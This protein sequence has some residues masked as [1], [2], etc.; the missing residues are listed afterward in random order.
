MHTRTVWSFVAGGCLGLWGLA[1]GGSLAQETPPNPPPVAEVTSTAEVEAL[2]IRLQEALKAIDDLEWELQ[3]A[4][5]DV[6][7]L[8]RERLRILEEFQTSAEP[9]LLGAF[10]ARDV[11]DRAVDLLQATR[12][13][14]QAERDRILQLV[15]FEPTPGAGADTASR[16]PWESLKGIGKRWGAR[17]R[18]IARQIAVLGGSYETPSFAPFRVPG[19]HKS[20]HDRITEGGLEG[21]GLEGVKSKIARMVRAVDWDETSVTGGRLRPN[22]LYRSAHHCDRGRVLTH[23]QAFRNG[24]ARVREQEDVFLQAFKSN[25]DEK[26][27]RALGAL[28]HALQDFFSHSN[29][30]DLEPSEQGSALRLLGGDPLTSYPPGLKITAY[31]PESGEP[32]EPGDDALDFVHDLN[33]K[34]DERMNAETR[35]PAVHAPSITKFQAHFEAAVIATRAEV[36]HLH[37]RLSREDPD[38]NVKPK[39]KNFGRGRKLR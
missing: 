20:V 33:C 13:W 16:D 7:D 15:D 36:L 11:A 22:A 31:F 2:R 34:D 26:A 12:E 37:E 27:H 4:R 30:V 39:W 14:E 28:L 38:F 1:A 23:E 18:E 24:V 32:G 17:D 8:E 35:S 6:E 29:F 10:A 19:L 9:L 5:Q 3:M 21:T 25:E